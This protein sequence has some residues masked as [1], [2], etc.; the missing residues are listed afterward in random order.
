MN[1]DSFSKDLTAFIN[2]AII[3][4][5][6]KGSIVTIGSPELDQINFVYIL[7]Q[8]KDYISHGDV[9]LIAL[10]N[11][12]VL[13]KHYFAV[14]ALGGVPV[15]ISP[16]FSHSLLPEMFYSFKV[17][18]I[19]NNYSVG[20]GF[21]PQKINSDHHNTQLYTNPLFTHGQVILTTTGTSGVG[22]GCVFDFTSLI[23]N[24]SKHAKAIG[25]AS[26]DSILINLPMYYSYSFV[27]QAI[28]ALYIGA[29]IVITN[30]PFNTKDYYDVICKNE[31]TISSL[32]PILAQKIITN[33]KP[34]PD[35]LRVI[36][37]GGDVIEVE[38]IEKMLKLRPNKEL[39]ITYG[40]TEAGP[41][42]ATLSAH[43]EPFKRL[44]SVGLPLPGIRVEI[45]K[46]NLSK[47][48]G[49]L[50]IKSDTLMKK[51]IQYIDE[52]LTIKIQDE[53]LSTGDFFTQDQDG[54]LYFK[55]RLSEFIVSQGE[56]FS[57]SYV[58]K[59]VKKIPN[60]D[61][62]KTNIIKESNH[63]KYDLVIFSKKLSV[64]DQSKYVEK[65]KITLKRHE[66]PREIYFY[67]YKED[68]QI[69]K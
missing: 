58:K 12:S 63:H 30:P 59:V 27:A 44:G 65:I 7:H 20:G 24:A 32:T 39:Y 61:M 54:Y 26:N 2:K 56:K 38:H 5:N 15:L 6:T 10:P 48:A 33:F 14:L 29:K 64:I 16:A 36:T 13:L 53:F 17:K 22:S 3:L 62:I 57:L 28:A 1:E 42:V 11:S 40:L 37:I 18:Y 69:V 49:E 19:I 67:D 68:M 55:G 60:I 25:M 34:L 52:V 51:K 66:W 23:N 50:I 41:R 35:C 8:W 9:V 21:K 47:D 45:N 43:S 31:V 46:T 4:F